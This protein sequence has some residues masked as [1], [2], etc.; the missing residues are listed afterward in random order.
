MNAFNAVLSPFTKSN[1]CIALASRSNALFTSACVALVSLYTASA[2]SLAALNSSTTAGI[3]SF[4]SS[5]VIAL[6]KSSAI[7]NAVL[8]TSVTTGF[9][10]SIALV[11]VLYALSISSWVASSFAAIVLALVNASCNTFH[12]SSV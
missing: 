7:F 1:I 3:T 6:A 10:L 4:K 2:S 9:K 5:S 12:V 11:K 8:S